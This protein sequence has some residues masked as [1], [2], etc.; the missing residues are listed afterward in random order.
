MNIA[1]LIDA[2]NILPGHADQIFDHAAS[3]GSIVV[4]EIYGAAQ[5]LT[6]WVEPVLKYAIHPNLTIKA[7]KGKNS[8]DIA[9][10]IGAMGMLLTGG[11]DT[12]IIASSDSDFSALSVRLRNAGIGVIGMG[13][14]KANPLWRTACTS[15]VVLQAPAARQA[16]Q[17]AAQQA[18]QP[19]QP[20]AKNAPKAQQSKAQQARQKAKAQPAEAAEAES[21]ARPAPEAK[22]AE[23]KPADSKPAVAATHNERIA[24]IRAFIQREIEAAGGKLLTNALFTTLNALPEYKVDQQRSR[25]RPVNYLMRQYG[26]VFAFEEVADGNSYIS[27]RADA[28][29]AEPVEAPA[30]EASE[31]PAAEPVESVEVP[32]VEAVAPAAESEAAEPET[33]EA[34]EAEAE[35]AVETADA[36]DPYNL[37]VA[38]GLP[39]D[40]AGQIV[41]IFTESASLREAYNKLRSTFGSTAGR[42]YYQKVKEIA[43]SR[44]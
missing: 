10:V 44:K 35:A 4:K 43:E 19:K 41:V 42:E 12:V 30:V 3:L 15:F 21:E 7:S 22:P 20:Q 17:K 26:D 27:M 6:T 11:F 25:R 8:S 32:V 28:P 31:A 1:I 36:D 29:A 5:A 13:T 24:I 37:L 39:E 23:A 18:A 33:V 16:Q 14:D 9:L 2:E 40:V 34:P 38:A